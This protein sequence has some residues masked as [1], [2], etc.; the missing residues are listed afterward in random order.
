LKTLDR[1]AA[2]I[3]KYQDFMA[4]PVID[5]GVALFTV[6]L[7]IISLNGLTRIM[8]ERTGLGQTG[9]S[10]LV[11]PDYLM[12]SDAFLDT[13]RKVQASFDKPEAGSVKTPATEAGL[14]GK[15]GTQIFK[16]Y[17]GIQSIVAYYAY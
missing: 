2:S 11:G 4:M 6:A 5:Q 1:Y 16:D 17:R 9:E 15:T 10:F 7:Q 14:Q 12:R 3:T 13:A 8:Q